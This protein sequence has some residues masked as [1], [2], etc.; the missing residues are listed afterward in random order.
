MSGL[1]GWGSAWRAGGLPAGFLF[2]AFFPLSCLSALSG[3]FLFFFT[4]STCILHNFLTF[5]WYA[6]GSLVSLARFSSL[7]GLGLGGCRLWGGVPPAVSLGLVGGG[8]FSSAVCFSGLSGLSVAGA[9]SRL[10]SLGG[11][12]WLLLLFLRSCPALW[13]LAFP[14]RFFLLA[15][16]WLSALALCRAASRALRPCVGWRAGWG[17]LAPWS[18]FRCPL[19]RPAAGW[20][21]VA[22]ALRWPVWW[23]VG[24][25]ARSGWWG[26]AV[27]S[28]V[29]FSPAALASPRS[30]AFSAF[31]S[32]SLVRLRLRSSFSAPGGFVVV[33]FFRCP[34]RA[35]AFARRWA[36]RLGVS[37]AVRRSGALWA[38]PVP[39][40]PVPRRFVVPSP[41]CVGG[42]GLWVSA[43]GGLRSFLRSLRGR[44]PFRGGVACG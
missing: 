21:S 5:L 19:G 41:V 37:V 33:A 34:A 16:L 27:A 43:V 40:A 9:V 17:C 4:Q 24:L 7:V 3:F 12:L 38:V 11:V 23:L 36:G 14:S 10:A 1:L 18:L 20:W 39:C 44:G 6:V 8:G 22:L 15:L 2:F 42:G 29:S 35:G 32:G 30:L 13:A 31:R 25:V 28:C 26:C